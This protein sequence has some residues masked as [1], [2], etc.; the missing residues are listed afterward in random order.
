MIHLVVHPKGADVFSVFSGEN[1]REPGEETG[2]P[3]AVELFSEAGDVVFVESKKHVDEL[4][5]LGVLEG[6]FLLGVEQLQPVAV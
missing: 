3:L 4:V 6:Q 5:E 2:D 1:L